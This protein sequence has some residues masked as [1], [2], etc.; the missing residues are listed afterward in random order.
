[1]L[2][3]LRGVWSRDQGSPGRIGRQRHRRWDRRRHR[4]GQAGERGPAVAQT[5]W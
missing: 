2:L 1:M 3:A 4:A 5:A